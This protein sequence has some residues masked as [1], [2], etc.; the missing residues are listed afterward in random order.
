MQ[1]ETKTNWSFLGTSNE[2]GR[3]GYRIKGLTMHCRS[4][5]AAAGENSLRAAQTLDPNATEVRTLGKHKYV[6]PMTKRVRKKL[7]TMSLPYPK[8][9]PIED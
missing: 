4:V 3:Q 1:T 2:G 7:S 9:E 6:Y 5:V 8:D